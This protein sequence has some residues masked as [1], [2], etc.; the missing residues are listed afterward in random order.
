MKFDIGMDGDIVTMGVDGDLVARSAEEFKSQVAKLR[1]KNFY[2]LVLEM[3]KVRFMD[4]S[5]LGA[6]MAVH[7]MLNEKRGMVVLT[8]LSDAVGKVFRLT[9]A[10]Q[11][12][13]I[14][15]TQQDGIKILHDAIVER[16]N[17]G[18][19]ATR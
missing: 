11:M 6:C 3:S 10:D 2:F 19:Q 5:G 17:E 4:S 8:K 18:S 14:A 7:K 16:R 9:R 13:K 12:L 15:P 1:D